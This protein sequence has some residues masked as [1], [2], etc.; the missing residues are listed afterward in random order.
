MYRQLILQICSG[1]LLLAVA[2]A[3]SGGVDESSLDCGSAI[4]VTL[5]SVYSGDTTHGV[6]TVANYNCGSWV[7]SGPELVFHLQ[8]SEPSLWTADLVSTGGAELDLILLDQCD[9]T[10]SCLIMVDSSVS[11]AP[12]SLGDFYLVVDGRDGDAGPF[13]LILTAQAPPAGP[14]D[15]SQ[16]AFFGDEGD[17]IPV[18]RYD[19]SGDTCDSSNRI[20]GLSCA[21]YALKGKD[22]FFE[23]TLL[24]NAM[25]TITI[26]SPVDAALWLLDACDDFTNANCLVLADASYAGQ[27]ETVTWI[28]DS[29]EM[30]TIWLV[31]DSWGTDTCG[32]FSGT[33]D[34]THAGAVSIETVSWGELQAMYR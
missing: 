6:N 34:L 11:S 2:G 4:E 22:E 5:D 20:D 23:I 17:V 14:C 25:V 27:A 3:A 19:I 24:K 16:Q 26:T 30:A 33:I 15:N 28:N 18:G 21:S 7:Q 1:V 29:D 13:E 32:S 31:V 9:E 8:V 12:N 10:N